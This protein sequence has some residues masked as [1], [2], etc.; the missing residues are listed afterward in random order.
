L[1]DYLSKGFIDSGFDM[2]WVHRTIANSDT[3]QRS[4]RPNE[5]NKLDERNFSRAVAR[6]L[7]AEVAYDAIQQ[8]TASDEKA[9]ELCENIKGRAIAIAGASARNGRN[10]GP[11]FALAVFGRSTRESN[12]DCDR[13]SEPSLLQTVFLQNDREILGLVGGSRGTWL[14]TVARDLQPGRQSNDA[15][16]ERRIV[17][18]ENQLASAEKQLERL[19][20]QKNEQQIAKAERR[21]ALI[22]KQLD[23]LT[24]DAQKNAEEATAASGEKIAGYVIDAYLRTLSRYP[25]E[26]ELERSLAYVNEAS[27]PVQGLGDVLW[28]VLNTKEFIVNH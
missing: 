12:C 10:N 15:A 21:I 20:K 9:Q 18:L 7:P 1:L 16:S 8:A 5:T 19:R 23:S 22:E 26:K 4:W 13:S 6:R 27:D 28:A 11:E 2:K 24:V 17:Q 14:D 3:Y 25:N